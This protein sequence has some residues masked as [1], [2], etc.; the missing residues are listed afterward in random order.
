MVSQTPKAKSFTWTTL[1]FWSVLSP[2]LC[3]LLTHDV[4]LG[5]SLPPAWRA[6]RE[7]TS[8]LAWCNLS[9][10]W[11]CNGGV[12]VLGF[13][14]S[15]GL[16]LAS[17]KELGIRDMSSSGSGRSADYELGSP[18]GKDVFSSFLEGLLVGNRYMDVYK[19]GIPVGLSLRPQPGSPECSFCCFHIFL[20][21]CPL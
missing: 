7:E 9:M 16:C 11:F 4:T 12:C 5:R 6:A 19:I 1:L 14:A 10:S 8:G 18:A 13:Y 2:S 20:S 15:K 17:N 3:S 21:F